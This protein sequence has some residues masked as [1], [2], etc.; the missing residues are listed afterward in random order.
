MARLEFLNYQ[1]FDISLDE[2]GQVKK[3]ISLKK[4]V[5]ELPQIFWNDASSWHEVNIWALERATA[6]N[7]HIETVKRN[8][9]HLKT[10]AAF[11]EDN[12]ADWR[13]FPI[14][15]DEQPL[16][17]FRGFLFGKVEDNFLA[18]STARNCMSAVIQFYRF[19]DLHNLVGNLFPMWKDRIAVIPFFDKA[20]FRRAMTK[21][22]P[23]LSIPNSKRSGFILEDGLLPLRSDHM[24]ELLRFTSEGKNDEL[25]LML[26]TGF[27][28]GAR[29]GTITTLTVSSLE[30]VRQDPN[31]PGIYLLR[32]GPGTKIATK[33]SVSGEIMIP[34]AIYLKLKHYA[35]STTRL[36]REARA[37]SENKNLLFLNRKGLPYS[38]STVNRLVY[39]MRKHAVENGL[40]HFAK[41]K[42]HQTRATFGTWLLKLLLDA[43]FPTS[44]AVGILRD[45]MLHK[46]ES[47]SLGYVTFLER[48]NAKIHFASE[49]NAA[50]TGLTN[51]DWSELHA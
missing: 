7:V 42:F 38:V 28:T 27:F 14:R 46:K 13:N 51:R 18:I 24:T 49:F 22:S 36:L 43:G 47:T 30:S 26:A 39:E 29:I 45:A 1:H 31:I 2:N 48:T 50:F 3:E 34:E 6:H 37:S 23:D 15:K 11:L 33:F 17:R 5:P 32:V 40:K 12:K 4:A 8:M 25:H 44:V 16:R 21:L 19:A 10:Y 9:K 20:G 35:T 41:F